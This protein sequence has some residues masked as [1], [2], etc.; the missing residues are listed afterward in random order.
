[1]SLLLRHATLID[2]AKGTRQ[3]GDLLIREGRIAQAGTS[4]SPGG[5]RVLEADGLIAAPGL[6][7]AHVHLRDPGQTYKEDLDVYKRQ[8][9]TSSESSKTVRT[10]ISSIK[11]VIFSDIVISSIHRSF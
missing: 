8:A 1:M 10:L 3:V 6:I 4:L 11:A 7:D 5:A 2:P 9:L